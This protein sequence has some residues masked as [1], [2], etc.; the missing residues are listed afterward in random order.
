MSGFFS[1]LFGAQPPA[2]PAGTPQPGAQLPTQVAPPPVAPP[3]VA[4]PAPAVEISPLDQ[5]KD[6]W[7]TPTAS[8]QIDTTMPGNIF[9]GATQDKMLTAA[10]SVDFAKTIPPEML[11]KVTAGGPDAAAALVAILNDVSQRAYAQSSFAATQIAET[12]LK[13]YNEGL[14]SRLPTKIRS[15]QT[16]QTIRE[17]N[18]ALQHPAA[19]PILEAM[20]S[21]LAVKY[22]TATVSE[23]N[24]MAT[25]YLTAFATSATPKA[26]E[27]VPASEDWGKFFQ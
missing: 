26:K 13:R 2:V 18:P 5:F 11:A 8:N 24:Q 19:A 17:S 4:P 16:A 25:Q 6:L 21:Q 20:Q 22:P 3:P 15:H 7:E 27:T 10:R 12:A 23:L 14:D 1:N 9:Q